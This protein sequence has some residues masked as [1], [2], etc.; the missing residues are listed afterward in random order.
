MTQ[1]LTKK[2]FKS[3]QEVRWCPGCGD[4][5]ILNAVQS[6][7][8]KLGKTKDEIVFVSG[9]GCS[10]RFPYYMDTFG[11]HSIHGRAAAV[12]T[13]VKTANP[14][15]SVWVI[16]GDGDGLSIGG[17]HTAHLLRRNLDINVILFNN[18]IYGLTKGQYSP[19]SPQGRRTKTSPMGSVDRPFN[20]LSFALGCNA[21]FVARTIDSHPKHLEATLQAAADHRGTSFVEVYQNCVIFNDGAFDDVASKKI[22]A[23]RTI[24]LQPGQPMI[25]GKEADKGLVVDGF[26]MKR[27]AAGDATVWDPTI[28]SAAPAFQMSTLDHDHEMPNPIGIFRSVEAGVFEEG[29]NAQ[30][31]AAIEKKG[32]GTLHDLVY[33]GET[34]EIS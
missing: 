17:N 10:S 26:E 16:T 1:S 15:L 3:D 14:D 9:I 32:A 8:T 27:C 4:Y 30:V 11:F 7:C 5:S 25:Y 22:R 13:G 20:P 28:E 24:D 18:E 23:D 33:S 6:V 21:T 29:V 12:A 2:D 31:D 34:W 19:T